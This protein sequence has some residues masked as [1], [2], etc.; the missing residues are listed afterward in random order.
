MRL[1]WLRQSD[2][3]KPEPGALILARAFL[4]LASKEDL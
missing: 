3:L 4:A 1:R 2:R